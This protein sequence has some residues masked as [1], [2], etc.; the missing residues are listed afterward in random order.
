MVM[1]G[2]NVSV[3][4]RSAGYPVI[5]QCVLTAELAVKQVRTQ[6]FIA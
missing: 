6:E 1:D 2:D 4:R 3:T 5:T